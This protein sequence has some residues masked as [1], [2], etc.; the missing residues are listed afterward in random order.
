MSIT[1]TNSPQ[2]LVVEDDKMIQLFTPKIIESLG[3]Q[4]D[5]AT[6]GKT[7]LERYADGAYDLILMDI[8]LP[9][10]DGDT[11]C[12]ILREERNVTIPIIG[13][14]ACGSVFIE[15]CLAAGMNDVLIKPVS[16]KQYDEC[17]KQHLGSK[18]K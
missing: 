9:D 6:D 1:Q 18:I 15:R 11:V 17:F 4:V 7:T 8:G 3:Y 14:T 12:R 13:H 2:I 10:I 16:V 5:I